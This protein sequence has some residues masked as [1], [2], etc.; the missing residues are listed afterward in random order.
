MVAALLGKKVGMTRMYDGQGVMTPVTVLQLGPCAILQVK[1]VETDGYN[2]LQL[3]YGEVK[4]SRRKEPEVGHAKK[5][6]TTPKAFVREVRVAAPPEQ[7]AGEQ[8]TVAVFQ[9][10]PFVAVTGTSKGKG[11]QG[12]MRRYR[13][14][15]QPASHGCERK[16][17]SPGGIG[18]GAGRGTARSIKKGKRMPGHMGFERSTSRNHVVLAVDAENHLLVVKGP[19]AGPC[20]GLVFVAQT[21][22]RH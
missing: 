11:Y 19:V 15:G 13:F 20:G 9:G 1:T 10:V 7:K 22:P 17:R 2:A 6:G 4:K 16:H 8:V 3:G 5:A 14:K 21:Q 18:G 12:V